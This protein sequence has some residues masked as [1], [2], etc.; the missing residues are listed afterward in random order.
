[1][2]QVRGKASWGLWLG[3]ACWAAAWSAPAEAT[4]GPIGNG[5]YTCCAPGGPCSTHCDGDSDQD[6]N[7]HHVEEQQ[8]QQYAL[9]LPPAHALGPPTWALR[10]EM[11]MSYAEPLG[12]IE[13]SLDGSPMLAGRMLFAAGYRGWFGG[14]ALMGANFQ[15]DVVDLGWNDLWLQVFA[16]ESGYDLGLATWG[17]A[18]Q[19][20]LGLTLRANAGWSLFAGQTYDHHGPAFG[21]GAALF[22]E[23]GDDWEPF[24]YRLWLDLGWVSPMI[25]SDALSRHLHGD[26][27]MLTLGGSMIAWDLSD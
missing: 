23:G 10:I 21:G 11:G 1:M 12:Q 3:V 25:E 9:P 13:R 24:R 16:L 15:S 6:N 17:D 5:C 20:K 8:Q 26:L 19:H 27:L 22:Y 14:L 2:G 7:N 18:A 4:C